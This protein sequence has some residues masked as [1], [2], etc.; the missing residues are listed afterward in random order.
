MTVDLLKTVQATEI[1]AR[2][3][4]EKGLKPRGMISETGKAP[5]Y[6]MDGPR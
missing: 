5:S 3:D 6:S 1:R 4:I 2:L